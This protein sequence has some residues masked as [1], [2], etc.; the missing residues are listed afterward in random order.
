MSGDTVRRT[1]RAAGLVVAVL[2]FVVSNG[3]GQP[4]PPLAPASGPCD[5]SKD[6]LSP[7]LSLEGLEGRYRL[8]LVKTEGVS[9]PRGAFTGWLY[10]WRTSER[11]SSRTTGRR[12]VPGDTARN[13]YFGTTDVDL[14]AAEAYGGD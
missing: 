13:L 3:A 10:L 6:A 11:D 7:D 1:V 9:R 5:S 8:T 2:G 14:D 12:A 4:A